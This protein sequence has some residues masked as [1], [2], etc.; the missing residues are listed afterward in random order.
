MPRGKKS[1]TILVDCV[2]LK[3]ADLNFPELEGKFFNCETS[4]IC[5]KDLEEVILKF[6]KKFFKN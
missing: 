6:L 5:G 1:E 2:A 4:K 3:I